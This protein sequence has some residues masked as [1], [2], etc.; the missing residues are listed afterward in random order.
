M[1]LE[2]AE[3]LIVTLEFIADE[4]RLIHTYLMILT[5]MIVPVWGDVVLRNGWR[6]WVD[7]KRR[8]EDRALRRRSTVKRRHER[9]RRRPV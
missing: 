8:R 3:N 2:I 4:L 5:A 7:L 9:R 1:D 6:A